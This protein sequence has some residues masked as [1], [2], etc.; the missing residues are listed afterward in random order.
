MSFEVKNRADWKRAIDVLELKFGSMAKVPEGNELLDQIH[1]YNDKKSRIS[2]KDLPLNIKRLDYAL[3]D[4]VGTTLIHERTQREFFQKVYQFFQISTKKKHEVSVSESLKA[5]TRKEIIDAFENNKDIIY[6]RKIYHFMRYERNSY[7]V[8]KWNHYVYHIYL[9]DPEIKADAHSLSDTINKLYELAGIDVS[10][11]FLRDHL[12][13]TSIAKF[14]F[15][16]ITKEKVV[17]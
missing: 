13:D 15:G 17:V 5:V 16:T 9:N 14:T 8:K 3:E 6:D 4:D 10:K 1:R 12:S 11:T 7:N 2:Q